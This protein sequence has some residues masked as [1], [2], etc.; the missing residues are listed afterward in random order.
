M[1][2]KIKILFVDD[3]SNILEALKRNLKPMNTLWDMHYATSPGDAMAEVVARHYDVVVSDMRMPE[4]NGAELLQSIQQKSPGTIRIILSGYSEAE[5]T[6]QAANTAHYYLSKPCDPSQLKDI[7]ARCC[8]LRNKLR[9]TPFMELIAGVESIPSPATAYQRALCYCEQDDEVKGLKNLKDLIKEDPGMACKVLKLVNSSFFGYSVGTVCNI[10]EAV[11]ML[12]WSTLKN[13]IVRAHIF[14]KADSN[15]FELVDIQAL[16]DES[17]HIATLAKKI[18]LD[19]RENKALAEAAYSIGL[20]HGIGRL[21][22]ATMKNK[23]YVAVLEKS[24]GHDLQEAEEAVFGADHAFVAAYLLSLWGLPDEVVDG[25]Y[26]MNNPQRDASSKK[27]LAYAYAARMM[28]R[29]S[30]N[31]ARTLAGKDG[32]D[33]NYLSSYNINAQ[34]LSQWESAFLN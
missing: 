2:D 11:D 7:I 8:E 5:Q 33:L 31:N 24:K 6:T 1:N 29:S 3:E 18:A 9:N 20:L 21:V 25:V 26:S 16:W 30:K 17:P 34:R 15:I 28:Y 13:L 32:I 27:A 10:E 22:F 19:S 23:E 4:V 12:G 14:S